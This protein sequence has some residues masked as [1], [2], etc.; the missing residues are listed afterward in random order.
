MIFRLILCA[1]FYRQ[2]DDRIISQEDPS[3]YRQ[4]HTSVALPAIVVP[5]EYLSYFAV[6]P[7][8]VEEYENVRS[9]NRKTNPYLPS[10]SRFREI[11]P[12][13]ELLW[14]RQN[15][16]GRVVSGGGREDEKTRSERGKSEEDAVS[17]I[18]GYFSVSHKGI[19]PM[20]RNAKK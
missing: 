8:E 16:D 20:E 13:K 5:R 6:K 4:R 3:Y 18:L 11:D 15:M 9:S 14:H 17:H 1:Q 7:P 10:S 19:V 2:L 12:V